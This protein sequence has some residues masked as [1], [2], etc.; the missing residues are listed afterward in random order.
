MDIQTDM[1]TGLS[2]KQVEQRVK[3]GLYNEPVKNQSKTVGQIIAG[4]VF[5]YFNFIFFIFTLMLILVHSYINM[6]FLPI[7][8][9]NML[10]GIVQEIRTKRV[11]DKL[12]LLNAS[13]STVIRDGKEKKVLSEELVLGDLCILG[14][15][16]QISADAVVIKGSVRVNEA[17]VTGEADEITKECG[18]KLLSGSFV[19]A[20]EC[21][22]VLEHV[23]LDSYASKIAL[24]AKASR[25]K[26]KTEMMSSLDKLVKTIGIA[27]IPVGILMLC[28]TYFL[29][30]HSIQQS[31][32]AVIAALVGMIPEG[33]Y[34]LTSVALVVS[35]MRLGKKNV[36]VHEMACV[37]TLARVNVLCVDKTGTITENKMS[38]NEIIS[39]R[40]DLSEEDI[41]KKIGN[42]VSVLDNDNNT[43][44]TLKEYFI[45]ST[46]LKAKKTFGFSSETKFSS[47]QMEDGKN[48]VI[49]APEKVLLDDYCTYQKQIEEYARRGMRVLIFGIYDGHL[50]G[51]PLKQPVVPIAIVVIGNA[52]RKEA[53]KTFEYFANQGVEIKVISGDNP[54]TVSAVAQE[55]GIAN[56]NM[57]VDASSLESDEQIEEAALNY[58]IFGRVQPE[59]KKRLVQALKKAGNVVA[60]TGDGVNDVLALKSADCS[61]AFGSGSE[62][63]SNVAQIVL[64]DSNFSCMPSVVLEGRRVVNNIQRTASLFIV[65]NIFS[66]LLAFFSLVFG[67]RYPLYPTQLSLLGAF[68][69][70]MPG[71]LLALQPSKSLIK[72]RF[73]RNAVQKALPAAITDFLLVGIFV[74]IGRVTNIAHEQ[75]STI[76]ILILLAVGM[77]ELIR[78]CMP[79][80]RIRIGV[81]IAM[82]I[83]IVFSVLFLKD[84]FAIYSLTV[85][86]R[87]K[88]ACLMVVAIPIFI[89]MCKLVDKFF[90]RNEK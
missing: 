34:L 33:L 73:L 44:N 10:I 54:L 17:L 62:A 51:H 14:A 11:L 28:Q 76:V 24:E 87:I 8:I 36:L 72:G 2:S 81:C 29:L 37:E 45:K 89:V 13:Y 43:M 30:N 31:V 23:G 4:N 58:T 52:I 20:G 88:T 69:I 7:I 26:Q 49:G 22:A 64:V 66:I 57:F 75:L 61:I 70:G 39:V 59:Q 47:A 85:T 50:D 77:C 56:S 1:N 86:L 15:G 48:Y 67:I 90:A 55:A 16:K 19:V 41:C 42:L 71:F 80:D 60:M 21:K 63:A 84:I 6:T 53:R 35:V 32:V 38:V 78:V 83:G 5:T 40:A 12:T 68:T 25:R 74:V 3:E 79:M 65:K 46:G 82:T 18:D 9:I 27:I